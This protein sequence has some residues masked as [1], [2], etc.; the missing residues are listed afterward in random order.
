MFGKDR[1]PRRRAVPRT[2]FVVTARGPNTDVR[3]DPA[4]GAGLHP[5][6]T[7]LDRQAT[8]QPFAIP[9]PGFARGRQKFSVT[10]PTGASEGGSFSAWN[11]SAILTGEMKPRE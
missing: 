5:Q 3:R 8:V 10:I 1:D 4:D 7:R 11:V 6:G 9:L 2:G